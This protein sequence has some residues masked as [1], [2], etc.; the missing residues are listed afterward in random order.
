I[1]DYPFTTLVPN[2][3]VV[4]VD[5]TR[6]FV[7][8][9]IPGLIEGAHTGAG[10]GHQFLRHVERTRLLVH[11]LDVSG[12]SGRDPWEDFQIVNRELEAYSE[13]LAG[14]PQLVALNKADS[15]DAGAII[16]SLRPRLEAK[17]YV[18]HPI[19]ALTGEKMQP[20]LNAVS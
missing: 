3:G 19:S 9:D 5:E 1:A 14:R 8:A 4:R 11:L 16:A 2:L 6:A 17:G 15:P 13:P 12:L 18:V 10:L 7:V 20:L